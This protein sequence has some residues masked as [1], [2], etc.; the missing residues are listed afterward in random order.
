MFN[1]IMSTYGA[2]EVEKVSG[3][4]QPLQ[5]H[6]RRRGLM[7]EDKGE[8][9]VR[10]TSF[11]VVYLTAMHA[12]SQSGVSVKLQKSLAVRIAWQATKLLERMPGAAAFTGPSP[13]AVELARKSWEADTPGTG[14]RY[15]IEP[16]PSG[17]DEV[18]YGRANLDDLDDLIDQ[19]GTFCAFVAD[20]ATLAKIV[21]GRIRLPVVTIEA[22]EDVA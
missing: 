10:Y 4:S 14:D 13:E 8:G 18:G 21:H 11:E 7:L 2:A 19:E 3:V 16:F 1:R 17:A 9:R 15:L 6:W 22:R 5:R 20:A 12:F